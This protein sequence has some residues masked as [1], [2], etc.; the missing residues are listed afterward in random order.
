M[1]RSEIS[2]ALAKALA[3]KQAGKDAKARYW[4]TQ[5]VSLLECNDI[6]DPSYVR[7]EYVATMRAGA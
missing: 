2:R 4:A 5:L 1:D 6:L 3:Y 7:G